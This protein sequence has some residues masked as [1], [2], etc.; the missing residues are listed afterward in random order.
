MINEPKSTEICY[1][2]AEAIDPAEQNRDHVLPR[3]LFHKEDREDSL[4]ILPTHKTCNDS[5]SQ[6]DEYFQFQVTTRAYPAPKARKLWEDPEDEQGRGPV[7]RGFHRPDHQR[8]KKAILKTLIPVEV[9]TEAGLYLGSGEAMTQDQVGMDRLL[10]VVNR[11]IRGVFTDKTGEI[12]PE[13]W[14]THSAMMEGSRVKESMDL[15]QVRF[16]SIGNGTVHYAWKRMED[17]DR[18]GFFWLIFYNSVHFWGVT[19]TKLLPLLREA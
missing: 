5:Y 11:I 8:F 4:I 2:C 12:L 15:L 18:E 13:D 14:P 1:I 17:D 9:H 16:T 10:R 7:M 6:D 19:G 3:S